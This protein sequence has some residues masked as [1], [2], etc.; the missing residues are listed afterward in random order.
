MG[1]QLPRQ[2]QYKAM[3]VFN[4]QRKKKK[5]VKRINSAISLK[6]KTNEKRRWKKIVSEWL[7]FF[8]INRKLCYQYMIYG[9][10][11]VCINECIVP[12]SKNE[13]HNK[14]SY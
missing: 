3:W 7:S 13:F 6:V 8:I 10:L 2:L 1:C 5:K 9:K 11:Y 12:F 14:V 4:L